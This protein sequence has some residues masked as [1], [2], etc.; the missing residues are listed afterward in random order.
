MKVDDFAYK[1]ALRTLEL[2]EET[3]HYKI[4][5]QMRKDIC[6]QVQKETNKLL[7]SK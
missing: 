4:P 5:D 1:V 3:Q 7:A 2:L 6:Q